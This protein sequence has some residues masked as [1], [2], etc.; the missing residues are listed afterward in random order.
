LQGIP[1]AMF[2]SQSSRIPVANPLPPISSRRDNLSQE[3]L[4][5]SYPRIN[6][7]N[8]MRIFPLW[9]HLIQYK[10]RYR[11]AASFCYPPSLTWASVVIPGAVV[12]RHVA[13][14]SESEKTQALQIETADQ[15]VFFCEG[16]T[17]Q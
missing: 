12:D 15:N 9:Y 16:D 11:A 14:V 2:A 6:S 8:M 5:L 17:I 7:G 4:R 10:A 13:A 3:N 1:V